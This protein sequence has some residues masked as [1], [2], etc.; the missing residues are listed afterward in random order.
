MIVYGFS[1]PIAHV[2]HSCHAECVRIT[3]ATLNSHAA[4]IRIWATDKLLRNVLLRGVV[5]EFLRRSFC[6]ADS[7]HE[8]KTKTE[9][10]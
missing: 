6:G 5:A 10:F 7:F 3:N 9:C 2:F 8:K 1:A 4:Y